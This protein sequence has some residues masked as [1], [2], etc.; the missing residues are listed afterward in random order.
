MN[1]RFHFSAIV[2]KVVVAG[3]GA[4]APTKVGLRGL[5]TSRLDLDSRSRKIGT[6][7][8]LRRA[9]ERGVV[10]PMVI[11][12]IV[13][14]SIILSELQTETGAEMA[15]ATSARDALQAEYTARSGV[16]LARLLIASEPTVRAA[17]AP[18]FAFM[19]RTPPQIPVWEFTEKLLS[20]F[21][22][23][24]GEKA[25]SSTATLDFDSEKGRNLRFPGGGFD[26]VIV[27]E[28]AKINVNQASSNDIAR[29]RLGK[30]IMG[31]ITPLQ[32]SSVFE[33]KD[34]Q[35]QFH[36]R[37]QVCS[38]LI[39]WCD[40]DETQFNC[41]FSATAQSAGA[42]DSYYA[43][44]PKPYK[45]RNSPLDSL[46]ELHM[47][48]GVTDDFWAT[49]V[50][51]EPNKPKKR[52]MTVWGQGT[53]NV[54]T[55]NPQTLLAIVCSG[56]P[57]AEICT[58]PAQASMFLTGVTMA[59]G[60]SM[61]APLFGSSQDFIQ[62][63]SGKGMLGPILTGIGMKPVKFQSEAEFAK[64]IATESKLFSIYAVGNKK[65]YKRETR[66]KTHAVVDFRTA[67]PLG[68]QTNGPGTSQTT[69]PANT[70]APSADA[71][72]AAN[73]PSSGGQLIYYR[74]E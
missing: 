74:M 60:V 53:V 39:D 54:N 70:S 41:D 40:V 27:D 6:G 5:L 16:N 65:G 44:L 14:L 46:D 31:L 61:G 20:A 3:S 67:A 13:V 45:R 33:L 2:A 29:I 10:L 21:I 73:K 50:D 35:G 19:K 1:D 66:V 49:F 52:I 12:A 47:V 28:D 38:A 51:P 59:R 36:D 15:A 23:E 4:S 43:L 58:D 22:G 55:A 32:Y 37:A 25:E 63:L 17:I 8:A 42:E 72:A 57:A 34:A 71:L 11:G 68:V 26:L 69:T 62:T 24:E 64:S 7:R 18:L 30:Q 9:R 56:A 48:R